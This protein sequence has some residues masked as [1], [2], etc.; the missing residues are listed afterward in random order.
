MA[1]ALMHQRRYRAFTFGPTSLLTSSGYVTTPDSADFTLGSSDWT[2]DFRVN[3]NEV[4]FLNWAGCSV[5]PTK[6]AKHDRNFSSWGFC[7][8]QSIRNQM[9]NG[10]AAV[11]LSPTTTTFNDSNWR[12][13]AAVRSG[14]GS[15]CS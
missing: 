15:T 10:A 7:W 14:S 1:R 12:H 2:V 9:Y 5:L 4:N 3:R 6:R 13:I 11:R 8:G